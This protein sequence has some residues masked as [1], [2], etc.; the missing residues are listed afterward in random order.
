MFFLHQVFEVGLGFKVNQVVT[1]HD[2]TTFCFPP[3]GEALSRY[4]SK[5]L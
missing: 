2:M 1:I 4:L 5:E 3:R